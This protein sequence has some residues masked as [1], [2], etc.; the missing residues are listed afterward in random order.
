[1]E[2]LEAEVLLTRKP[3]IIR[4]SWSTFSG[5]SKLENIDEG[6]IL[7]KYKKKW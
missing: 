5:I 6:R 4:T 2:I 7:V 3:G 1:M